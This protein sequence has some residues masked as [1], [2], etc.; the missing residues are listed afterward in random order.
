ME[1]H[2]RET[3]S[4]PK[5]D[6]GAITA[7]ITDYL[8]RQEQA[9]YH[10]KEQCFTVSSDNRVPSYDQPNIDMGDIWKAISQGNGKSICGSLP[11]WS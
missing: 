11:P 5:A 7:T 6:A 10:T 2:S 8:G 9:T 4:K 3:E 1:F